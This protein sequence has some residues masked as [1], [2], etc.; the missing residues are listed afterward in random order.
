VVGVGLGGIALALSGEE[1]YTLLEA[2]YASGLVGMFVPLTVAIYMKKHS[3]TAALIAMGIA[4]AIWSIEFVV[5]LEFPFAGV[6][7]LVSFFVYVALVKFR[8]RMG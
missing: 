7:T 2:A 6:A 4:F 3:E 1:A 8:P 5:E